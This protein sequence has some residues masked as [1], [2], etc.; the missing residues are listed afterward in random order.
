M[1]TLRH[2]AKSAD[3]LVAMMILMR[4]HG[5]AWLVEGAVGYRKQVIAHRA[6]WR[7]A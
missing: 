2:E 1:N 5:G 3:D 7:T 4:A 6:G